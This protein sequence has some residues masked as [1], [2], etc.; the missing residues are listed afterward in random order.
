M[1][2]K[3]VGN[4]QGKVNP[5]SFLFSSENPNMREYLV[6][7]HSEQILQEGRK[8]LYILK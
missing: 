4:P 7:F 1:G 6:L 2:P 5:E 3:G 8:V